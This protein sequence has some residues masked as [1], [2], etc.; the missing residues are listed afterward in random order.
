MVD[1]DFRRAQWEEKLP[2]DDWY[3]R[4][5]RELN[6]LVFPVTSK[7]EQRKL[8]RSR[9]YE[10]VEELLEG[11]RIPLAEDGPNMDGERK[12][13]DTVVV[14]H[15]DEEGGIRLGKLSAIGLVR[16][17]A[18][19]YLR[20]D[21]LGRH[22]RGEAIW[23]GHFREGAMVFFAYHWLVRADGTAERL[24]EDG[25][26]G[27]HAGNWEINTRSVG[28]A[29]SGRYEEVIPPMVQIEGAARL[30]REHYP[31]VARERV[32]GHREVVETSCPGEHFL[33]GW[34]QTLLGRM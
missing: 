22:V 2:F 3:I 16:Q 8:F 9:V 19:Q 25:A 11:R 6:E 29:L 4:L 12:A 33:A 18:F 20:D 13:V 28:L 5:E 34:K 10:L 24:L 7:N 23:S 31:H 27:W 17:Y 30:V 32:L 1:I 15:T 14:H 26:I 21:V